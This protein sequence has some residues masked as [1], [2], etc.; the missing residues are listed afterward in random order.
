MATTKTKPAPKW[1]DDL[2]AEYWKKLAPSVDMTP[3]NAEILA[4]LCDGLSNYR[5]ASTE[6]DPRLALA[7]RRQAATQV[8][9]NAKSLNINSDTGGDVLQNFF[10]GK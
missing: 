2:A 5:K 8:K 6:E 1:L 9:D 7:I 3:I 10:G 4:L